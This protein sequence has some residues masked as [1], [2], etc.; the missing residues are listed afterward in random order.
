MLHQLTRCRAMNKIRVHLS[1]SM[2][3]HA[4]ALNCTSD[5]AWFRRKSVRSPP[6][7]W[8]HLRTPLQN[9]NWPGALSLIHQ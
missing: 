8:Q 6:M 2:V 7:L 9:P 1:S 3:L 4:V 5:S